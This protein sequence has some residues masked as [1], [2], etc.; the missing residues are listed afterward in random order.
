MDKVKVD[1]EMRKRL[2]QNI[3][4]K[5]SSNVSVFDSRIIP[6]IKRYGSIAAMFA[7][8]FVGA[9]AVMHLGG[10]QNASA[11]MMESATEA[12]AATEEA[13]TES[14]YETET[15]SAVE[16]EAAE[17]YEEMEDEA[18]PMESAKTESAGIKAESSEKT[19]SIVNSGADEEASISIFEY[20]SAAELSEMAD[21]TI[22]DI[23]ELLSRSTETHYLLYEDGLME[24][25]YFIEG[26]NVYFRKA[27]ES[28]AEYFEDKNLLGDYIDFA[29]SV[30]KSIAGV[31]VTLKG[32]GQTYNLANWKSGSN[33]YSLSYEKGLS[34]SEMTALID[35]IISGVN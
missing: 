29:D 24:I 26:G 5:T 10:G 15:D 4:E 20:A 33:V 2:L 27:S 14:A 21:N 7:V 9:Y 19:D 23:P 13:Y 17:A 31:P 25:D 16:M 34:E 12:P 8:V 28:V 22:S 35:S 32:S 1:D 11:P 6:F 30:E 18:A 3:E